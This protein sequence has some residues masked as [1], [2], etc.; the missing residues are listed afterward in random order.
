ME[1]SARVY[2]FT[3]EGCE[4][5]FGVSAQVA[6]QELERLRKADGRVNAAEIVAAAAPE[7]APLHPVFEWNDSLAAQQHREHQ[8]RCLVRRVQVLTEHRE[9]PVMVAR[10]AERSTAAEKVQDFDPLADDLKSAVGSL[11]QTKRQI[12]SLRQKAL[13]RFDRARTIAANVALAELEEAESNLADAGE[14]LTASREA[15]VWNHAVAASI[16]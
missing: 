7:D 4:E 9:A 8:A 6:G 10:L 13:R 11:L 16:G 3:T 1:I 15:S 2:A 12:E 5:A 14:A